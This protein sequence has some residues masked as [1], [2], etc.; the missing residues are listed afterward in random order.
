MAKKRTAKTGVYLD[1]LANNEYVQE[2]LV[3][4]ADDL[5]AAYKRASSRRSAAKAAQDRKVQRRVRHGA[6]AARDAFQVVK[7]GRRRRRHPNRKLVLAAVAV[8][9]AGA[10]AAG[11]V[12]RKLAEPGPGPTPQPGGDNVVPVPA[13]P[14]A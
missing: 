4:A 5:H 12:R 11:P 7:T 8:A 1:R 10:A 13:Q 14:A 9:G 6:E 3:E 2:R